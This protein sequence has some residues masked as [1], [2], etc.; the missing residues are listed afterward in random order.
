MGLKTTNTGYPFILY[1]LL[2]SSTFAT[3]GSSQYK[4]DTPCSFP[5]FL[6][7]LL[8]GII[9]YIKVNRGAQAEKLKIDEAERVKM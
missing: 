9:T 3:L 8:Q 6:V 7:I 1:V 5:Y 4:L 2:E